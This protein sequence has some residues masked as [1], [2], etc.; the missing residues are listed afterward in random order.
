MILKFEA[1]AAWLV[2]MQFLIVLD[3]M[4]IAC[5][6]FVVLMIFVLGE[7]LFAVVKDSME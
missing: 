4:W 1:Y 7:L 3:I 2:V 5:I 6:F